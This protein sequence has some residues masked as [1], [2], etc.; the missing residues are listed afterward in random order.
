MYRDI[1]S[2]MAGNSIKKYFLHATRLVCVYD[3]THCHMSCDSSHVPWHTVRSG[4]TCHKKN[5]YTTRLVHVY[6]IYKSIY[7]IHWRY[8]FYSFYLP[9]PCVSCI[10][11]NEWYTLTLLKNLYTTRRVHVYHI[12]MSIYVILWCYSL[13]SPMGWLRL[14]GSFEL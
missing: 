8:S 4:G 11:V 5:L 9:S 12:Y 2:G 1:H 14:V 3:M 7:D 6:H 10:H 13:H